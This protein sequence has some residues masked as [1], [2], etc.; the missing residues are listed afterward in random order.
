MD[1][2]NGWPCPA[3]F[4]ADLASRTT[5]RVGGRAEWL[6]E[7]ADPEQLRAAW[8]AA[9]ERGLS[10]RILGGG[11]NLLIADGLLSGVVLSTERLK[12]MF[13][14]LSEQDDP[15]EPPL[16]GRSAPPERGSDAR[17]VAWCG[18]TLP[19]LV[20]A[21]RNLGWSGLE[22]LVGVPGQLGGG[23]AMNAGGRWGELWDV[24]E[25]VRVID[26]DGRLRDL[27]R[28]QCAPCYR[29]GGIEGMLVVAAVLRLS[30]DTVG[31]V[32]ERGRQYLLEKRRAQPV[33]EWSCGCIF[34]NPGPEAAGGRSA[35]Q[36]I[37]DCDGKALARGDAIVSPLHANF[38]INRGR[39]TAG[40][41]LDLIEAV[42]AQV[43]DRS[44]VQLETEARIW[45]AG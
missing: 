9:R 1:S 2:S 22:S 27:E 38:I 43:L 36:L 28:A 12:R 31:A 34:R 41:V 35:G 42:R 18:T 44:G 19:T 14:P 30:V 4:E 13:R 39:A 17:L 32:R 10:P 24:V 7:P 16:R 37:E 20:T 15:F 40:E 23:V 25:L 3:L 45:R 26:Q 11:A 33:T 8:V 29:D 21:A 5:L 6:L